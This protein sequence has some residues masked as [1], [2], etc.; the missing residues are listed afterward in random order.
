MPFWLHALLPP[1][2]LLGEWLSL[3]HSRALRDRIFNTEFGFYELGTVVLAALAAFAIIG[4]LKREKSS[5]SKSTRVF[6]NLFVLGAIYFAGEEISW[7][8]TFFQWETPTGFASLNKQHETNLHNLESQYFSNK[9]PRNLLILASILIT[10][11]SAYL[12]FRS[13][14]SPWPAA[15]ASGILMPT[16]VCT[17]AAMGVWI[18][19]IPRSVGIPFLPERGETQEFYIAMMLAVYAGSLFLRTSAARR[20]A[21]SQIEASPPQQSVP[22]PMAGELASAA[23]DGEN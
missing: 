8:Q 6:L 11:R 10:L 7:G 9:L 21:A 4:T 2:P 18:P 19:P 14:W 13:K 5:L 17:V 12:W 16:A 23:A 1:L 22:S 20:P 15:K 3:Q